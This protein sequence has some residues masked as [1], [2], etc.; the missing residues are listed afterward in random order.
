METKKF[1][2]RTRLFALK[3]PELSAAVLALF[4]GSREKP[5]PAPRQ[6]HVQKKRGQ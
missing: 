6:I 3:N 2:V 5:V 4:S 1:E